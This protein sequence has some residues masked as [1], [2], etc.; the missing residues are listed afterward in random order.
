MST[1]LFNK[2]ILSHLFFLSYLHSIPLKTTPPKSL[3]HT[4]NV[5]F[6]LVCDPLSLTKAICVTIRIEMSTG[7]CIFWFVLLVPWKSVMRGLHTWWFFV[8]MLLSHVYVGLL[9]I[10][11]GQAVK[12]PIKSRYESL[13]EQFA[14]NFFILSMFFLSYIES[15][16]YYSNSITCA[17]HSYLL[18]LH[19]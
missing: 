18:S 1:C 15:L 13:T 2:L 6:G 8:C 9:L 3:S 14:K 10:F 5:W 16:Q 19:C 12:I 4:H 7:S 17:N 11:V